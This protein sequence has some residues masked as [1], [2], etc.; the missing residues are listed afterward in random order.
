MNNLIVW[1]NGNYLLEK[2]FQLPATSQGLALGLG[3]FETLRVYNGKLIAFEKH[4]GRLLDG[5]SIIGGAA[6][7][8]DSLLDAIQGVRERNPA[9]ASDASLKIA[10]Y[11]TAQKSVTVVS[12][13]NL[14]QRALHSIV[15]L[16]QYRVNEFSPLV[17]V[18][19]T[20]YA[21]NLLAL[22]DA[23]AKGADEALMLNTKGELCEGATSN[24][25]FVKNE[26]VCTPH[27]DSGCLPGVARATVIEV[28]AKIGRAVREGSYSLADLESADEA[29]LT[30]SLRE[31]QPILRLES[32]Q[33]DLS[34][35]SVTEQLRQEYKKRIDGIE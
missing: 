8:A 32:C 18:K 2:E 13:A 5:A 31:I 34:L 30:S 26:V 1:V 6:P 21:M 22:K 9:L 11:A 17:G 10:I 16:S 24:V 27:L 28:C 15:K 7:A 20:S 14:P 23:S 29:F 35:G 12:L 3:V 4:Y 33:Y 25:F 19:S